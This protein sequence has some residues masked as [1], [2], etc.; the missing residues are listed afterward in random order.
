MRQSSRRR[1]QATRYQRRPRLTS[2]WGST[3]RRLA[4]PSR[5]LYSK[6]RPSQSRQA[7][8][9]V[10]SCWGSTVGPPGGGGT[11]ANPSAGT[12]RRRRAGRAARGGG[13]GPY[14]GGG[15]GGAKRRGQALLEFEGRRV[16]RPLDAGHGCG[17]GGAQ[18]DGDRNPLVLVEEQRGHRG[19]GAQRVAA[20]RS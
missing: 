8:A 13:A 7:A 10:V 6:R 17:G 18:P 2:V 20:R 9:I 11:G 15:P 19:P 14:P 16:R 5:L 12:R 1:S 3:S 4:V